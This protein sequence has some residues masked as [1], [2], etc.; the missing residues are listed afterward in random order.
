MTMKEQIEVSEIDKVFI[1]YEKI[2]GRLPL[3]T[4]TDRMQ[5]M[6]LGY[7][8]TKLGV[9]NYSPF[10]WYIRGPYSIRLSGDMNKKIDEIANAHIHQYINEIL[11]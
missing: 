11:R 4:F 3:D 9:V 5:M 2:V 1:F 8:M 6:N 10:S 7:L